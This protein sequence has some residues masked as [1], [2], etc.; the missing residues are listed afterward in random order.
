MQSRQDF[1]SLLPVT[2]PT[3]E[4]AKYQTNP[5]ITGQTTRSSLSCLA[6]PAVT[7]TQNCMA[8]PAIIKRRRSWTDSFSPVSPACGVHAVEAPCRND[9]SYAARNK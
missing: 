8:L 4:G 9:D 3:T 1:S 2:P 7:T 5:V 6:Y